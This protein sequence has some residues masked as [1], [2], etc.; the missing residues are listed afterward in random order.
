MKKTLFAMVALVFA[1][2]L[3]GCDT[4]TGTFEEDDYDSI[5]YI[6]EIDYHSLLTVSGTVETAIIEYSFEAGKSNIVQITLPWTYDFG[7]RK[8]ICNLWTGEMS[9]DAPVKFYVKASILPTE[10]GE[11]TIQKSDLISGK[12][13]APITNTGRGATVWLEQ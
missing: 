12:E 10:D 2:F 6:Y 13:Y 3:S 4:A 7:V 9:G 11:I 1:F 5:D 8:L